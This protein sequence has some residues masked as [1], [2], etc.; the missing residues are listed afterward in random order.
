MS[1]RTDVKS[2]NHRRR[3]G[4]TASATTGRAAGASR[5][6]HSAHDALAT[7]SRRNKT[8]TLADR[9][10][11]RNLE[12]NGGDTSAEN[13]GYLEGSGTPTPSE[14]VSRWHR[15][16][17]LV[18][19]PGAGGSGGSGGRGHSQ[20]VHPRQ[21]LCDQ[22]MAEYGTFKYYNDMLNGKDGGGKTPKEMN[23]NSDETSGE[24]LIEK[25]SPAPKKKGPRSIVSSVR[26]KSCKTLSLFAFIVWF[27][28]SPLFCCL[29]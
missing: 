27:I 20:Q 16:I 28:E 9:E 22:C 8:I 25:G 21:C 14:K 5:H 18:S 10:R 17:F 29:G 7:T 4:P 1:V 13:E 12:R 3:E 15:D 2:H 23:K 6:A 11:H 19:P 24:E 26:K